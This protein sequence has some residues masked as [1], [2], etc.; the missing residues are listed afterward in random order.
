M[1]D[2]VMYIPY[3][4]TQITTSVYYKLWFK[5]WTL[6]LM[7]QPIRIHKNSTKLLSQRIRKY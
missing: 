3:D 6:N 5:V 7:I 4:D 1:T 2:K